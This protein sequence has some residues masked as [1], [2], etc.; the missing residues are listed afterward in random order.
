MKPIV[1]SLNCRIYYLIYLVQDFL[2]E[3]N[4]GPWDGR[5]VDTLLTFSHVAGGKCPGFKGSKFQWSILRVSCDE[6]KSISGL[7]IYPSSG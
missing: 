3:R 2:Y 7:L 4:W 6:P 5:P 1:N